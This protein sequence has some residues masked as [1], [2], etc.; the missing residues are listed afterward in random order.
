MAIAYLGTYVAVAALGDSLEP[1]DRR[2]PM[3]RKSTL[4]WMPLLLAGLA[5]GGCTADVED[6]GSMPDVD[7][8]G[9]DLPNIDVDRA[10]VDVNVSSD[11]QHVVVPDVDVS[12]SPPR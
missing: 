11:T 10:D 5:A 7:V 9:G 3:R 1:S 4:F 12:T 2:S 6:T 8:E